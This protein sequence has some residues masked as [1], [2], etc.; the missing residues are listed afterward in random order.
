MDSLQFMSGFQGWNKVQIYS[1]G[2]Q[3]EE[4]N[5]ERH[6]EERTNSIS[7]LNLWGK[8]EREGDAM[9]S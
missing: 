2:W 7:G 5:T 6:Y 9:F 1:G 3:K 8:K 4:E